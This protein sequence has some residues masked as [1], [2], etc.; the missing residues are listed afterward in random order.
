M[1]LLSFSKSNH[2]KTPVKQSKRKKEENFVHQNRRKAKKNELIVELEETQLTFPFSTNVVELLPKFNGDSHH[3]D[4]I[5][6]IVLQKDQFRDTPKAFVKVPIVRRDFL[7]IVC[8]FINQI[9]TI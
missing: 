2:K 1:I 8:K 4:V 9:K 6:T 3:I 5:G 7:T